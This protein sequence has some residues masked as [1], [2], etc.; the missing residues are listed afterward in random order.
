M[1]LGRNGSALRKTR[2]IKSERGGQGR[3]Q[4]RLKR[5]AGSRERNI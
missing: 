2:K 5:N 4:E 1:D 3:V